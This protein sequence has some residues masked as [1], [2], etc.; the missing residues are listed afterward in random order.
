MPEARRT[1]QDRP[2]RLQ[3]AP[4]PP[5]I[6]KQQ[7]AVARYQGQDLCFSRVLDAEF[8]VSSHHPTGNEA[9]VSCTELVAGPIV[10]AHRVKKFLVL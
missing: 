2:A 5:H 8:P 7:F 4:F 3:R 1:E 9:I 6:L 10:I